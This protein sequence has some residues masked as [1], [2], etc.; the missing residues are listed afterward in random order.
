MD[1]SKFD[2]QRFNDQSGLENF[3]FDFMYN[4]FNLAIHELGKELE[5]EI[6]REMEKYAN[7]PENTSLDIEISESK[8]LAISEMNIVYLYKDFEINLKRLL[9]AAYNINA[10]RL[11]KWHEVVNFLKSKKIP[12]KNIS[13]ESEIEELRH[14]NNFLKHSH[15]TKVSE[16][17][18]KIQ[19]FKNKEKINYTLLNDFFDR[20]VNAPTFFLKDLSEKIYDDLYTFD[21]ER[22]D[23]IA[24]QFALRMDKEIANKFIK[25]LEGK[26]K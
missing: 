8:L 4:D 25:K 5:K 6:N 16:E 14:L 18:K 26:Y 7:D 1:F 24:T 9:V 20:V 10:K 11:Y 12:I 19:E 15:A 2:M 23:N 3:V 13:N 17:I 22:L 21:S